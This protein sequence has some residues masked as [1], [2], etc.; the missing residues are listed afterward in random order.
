MI[1]N[2]IYILGHDHWASDPYSL[3]IVMIMLVY[4]MVKGTFTHRTRRPDL[5]LGAGE[6]SR[7]Q[8]GC[9]WSWRDVISEKS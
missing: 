9:G 1:T 2:I 8:A 7:L 3:C 4:G 6:K 5:V